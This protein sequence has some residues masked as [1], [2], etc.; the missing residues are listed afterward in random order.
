VQV[1]GEQG[2]ERGDVER[3]CCVADGDGQAWGWAG[4]LV[5]LLGADRGEARPPEARGPEGEIGVGLEGV[6][7]G[8]G[9]G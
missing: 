5:A 7:A 8:F 2:E 4:V 9:A 6:G 3:V 1:R